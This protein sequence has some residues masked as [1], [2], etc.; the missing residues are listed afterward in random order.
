MNKIQRRRC[1]LTVAACLYTALAA[2]TA[3]ACRYSVRDVGFV[4]MG[5]APYHLYCYVNQEASADRTEALRQISFAALLE[6]NIETEVIDVDRDKEHDAF[7]YLQQ[8]RIAELPAAV[9]V[10]PD[11]SALAIPLSSEILAEKEKLWTLME[12]VVN[13]PKREELVDT[14]VE[15]YGVV[16]LVEGPD[17]KQNKEAGMAARE[18][19]QEIENRMS[20]MDKP[21]DVPPKLMVVSA[22]EYEK[23]RVLLWSLGIE[24][25][26]PNE[27]VAAVVYGKARR[28]GEVLRGEA[29]TPGGLLAT[30]AT[31]GQSC[32]CGLER[33]W[34]MGTMLP[35]QWSESLREQS[36][37]LL[38]FDPESP[39]VKAEISQ[40]LSIS[41]AQA[42][43]GTSVDSLLLG[44][45]ESF[46]IVEPGG[47]EASEPGTIAGGNRSQPVDGEPST[48]S[49]VAVADTGNTPDTPAPPAGRTSAQARPTAAPASQGFG[50]SLAVLI[51]GGAGILILAGGMFIVL[52]ARGKNA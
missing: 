6:S 35:I 40:I 18:A 22:D 47:S 36:A 44:Y 30:L 15:A 1:G 12:S 3:M 13:S 20:T 48:N 41:A 21:V 26:T 8:A 10:S 37:R 19:I 46:V 24:E 25:N 33:E 14:L 4:D 5:T 49:L 11:D 28:I 17:A 9:L 2:P 34:M 16:V 42:G 27:A 52:L 39:V 7:D 43:S 31:I 23:E 51:L 38:G 45:S 29:I 50:L 32:E